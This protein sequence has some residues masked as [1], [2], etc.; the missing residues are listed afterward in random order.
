M[1][2]S[3]FIYLSV[4]IYECFFSGLQV[5]LLYFHVCV[6][7]LSITYSL[8][9]FIFWLFYFFAFFSEFIVILYIFCII[10]I[11][12]C[13]VSVVFGV[14]LVS[15]FT[16]SV[17]ESLFFSLFKYI[18]P[19]LLLSFP[20]CFCLFYHVPLI[21]FL[22]FIIIFFLLQRVHIHLHPNKYY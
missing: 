4:F 5:F 15:V 20:C 17:P 1:C 22:Q 9:Y 12:L 2:L 14:F 13:S 3:D 21:I 11:I 6:F 16:W 7:G 19:S 8:T 18:F 10:H